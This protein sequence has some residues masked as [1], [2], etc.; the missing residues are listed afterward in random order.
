MD[1]Y[2]PRFWFW[3]GEPLSSFFWSVYR[4]GH[5]Y[6]LPFVL[7]GV[8]C[9][10]VRARR[11]D[12]ALFVLLWWL[13]YPVPAA[14]ARDLGPH[15]IRGI[16]GIPVLAILAGVGVQAVVT[17]DARCS[18]TG[19]AV[20]LVLLAAVVIGSSGRFLSYYVR[21]YPAAIG[22]RFRSDL[23]DSIAWLNARQEPYDAGFVMFPVNQ[24]FAYYLLF[25]EYDPAAV[26]QAAVRREPWALGFEFV[27]QFD[28][29]Y[30]CPPPGLR[31]PLR[32]ADVRRAVSE[33]M[34]SGARVIVFAEPGQVRG[35]SPIATFTTPGGRKSVEVHEWIVGE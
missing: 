1:H 26:P 9:L 5:V 19:R 4:L 22:E 21:D 15:V 10:L 31:P 20:A 33:T 29:F 12:V 2:D 8:G 3:R 23:C 25:T 35:S 34:T 11:S 17:R 18:Q 30:F 13:L 16:M 28:R 7:I 27:G 24:G 14:L 32:E 6:E